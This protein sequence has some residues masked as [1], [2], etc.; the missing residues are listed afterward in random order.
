M[1]FLQLFQNA[2]INPSKDEKSPFRTNVASRLRDALELR[3]RIKGQWDLGK[4]LQ[5]IAM[6]VGVDP[7]VVF[8]CM[9]RCE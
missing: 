3:Q 2:Y 6:W 1:A 5:E 9:M 8:T 7:Y 4:H